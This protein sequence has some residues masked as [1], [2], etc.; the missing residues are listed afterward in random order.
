MRERDRGRGREGEGVGEVEE[1]VDASSRAR[2]AEGLPMRGVVGGL[3]GKEGRVGPSEL[4][5]Y[6][7]HLCE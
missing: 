4:K 1:E 5:G 7:R 6:D 2:R 3:D